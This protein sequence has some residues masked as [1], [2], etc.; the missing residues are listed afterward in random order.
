MSYITKKQK[1]KYVILVFENKKQ[2]KKNMK[3]IGQLRFASTRPDKSS[4]SHKGT[5]TDFH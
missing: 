5:R 3:Q 4:S 1:T 2:F